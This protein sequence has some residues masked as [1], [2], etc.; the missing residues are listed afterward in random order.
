MTFI[1]LAEANSLSSLIEAVNVSVSP[2]MKLSP[3]V[4]SVPSEDE[5]SP[6]ISMPASVGAVV[7]VN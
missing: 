4:R 5:N 1:W 7:S 2:I 6:F 3:A